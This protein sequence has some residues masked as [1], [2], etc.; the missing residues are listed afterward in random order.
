MLL[1][2]LLIVNGCGNVKIRFIRPPQQKLF[3]D[4]PFND[5]TPF[6]IE[7]ILYK[8]LLKFYKERG[9]QLTNK[10]MCDV[11]L[12][13]TVNHFIDKQRF[14]SR[15]IILLNKLIELS[16]NF[17]LT[18]KSGSLIKNETILFETILSKSLNP[19][20]EWLYSSHYVQSM[21]DSKLL[22][23]EQKFRKYLE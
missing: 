13:S 21:L 14:I 20:E 17:Q 19:Q 22:R 9:Y 6:P 23:I 11:I 5:K 2:L 12:T 3:I 16:I 8:K 18:T 15:D 1:S 10:A 7:K 4:F